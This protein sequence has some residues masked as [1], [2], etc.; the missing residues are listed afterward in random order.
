MGAEMKNK[1]RFLLIVSIAFAVCTIFSGCT[2][3]NNSGQEHETVEREQLEKQEATNEMQIQEKQDEKVRLVVGGIGL[4]ESSITS[5]INEFNAANEKYQIIAEDYT[6]GAAS[7]DQALTVMQTK[8]M[9]GK[10]PDIISFEGISPLKWIGAEML[11]DMDG[12]VA[13]DPDIDEKDIL[14]WKALHEYNGL[15]LI[16][17]TFWTETLACSPE[18]MQKY[19]GWTIDDYLEIENNLDSNQSMIYY[20]NPE[21]FLISIGGRYL[22]KALD[23]VNASCDFDN[24]EF[25]SILESAVQA[26]SYE[27]TYDP[28]ETGQQKVIRGKLVCF[29]SGLMT[30][31]DVAFDRE[32]C[33]QT[34]SYIGWPTVDGSNGTDIRLIQAVGIN[35]VSKNIEGCW[36]FMKF[37]LKNP[38]L[39]N[40]TSGMPTYAPLVARTLKMLNSGGQKLKTTEEDMEIVM[41]LASES[42]SL[43][44]YD[45]EVM[46]IILDESSA[47]IQG[48]VSAHETAK[49][50]QSRVSLY[51]KEQYE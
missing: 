9:T 10:G 17:P 33:G 41:N 39:E 47:F 7:F 35:K 28:N 6:D 25:I 49:R 11:Y 45:E 13:E 23:L 2:K 40:N 15:F 14:I 38:I 19:E 32:E 12:L 20:M 1:R 37:L 21:N 29:F 36:E 34:L 26:G 46:N 4:N 50:I 16:S 18:T 8:V 27:A 30:G 31:Q 43:T 51:M 22:Q 48:N 5:V 44:Y 24:E 42:E 3:K